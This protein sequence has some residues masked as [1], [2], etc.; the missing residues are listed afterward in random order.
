MRVAL[1]TKSETLID[2]T[3]FMERCVIVPIQPSN[4]RVKEWEFLNTQENR[5]LL[6]R[7]GTLLLWNTL[8]WTMDDY[9]NLYK[10]AKEHVK[11]FA[12]TR[13]DLRINERPLANMAV[14]VCGLKFLKSTLNKV[15]VRE[16][17][18]RL[19]SLC[20][21]I[22]NEEAIRRVGA[23]KAEIYK[24]LSD[25]AWITH[26]EPE[27]SA[28]ALRE[29]TEY[30]YYLDAKGSAYLDIDVRS[31][32]VKYQSW[33]KAR[34]QQSHYSNVEGFASALLQIPALESRSSP[35]SPL[36]RGAAGVIFR[37]RFEEIWA[38][39]VEHFKGKLLDGNGRIG[40]PG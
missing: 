38:E 39:D 22:L 37:F 40:Q 6:S 24:A 30:C 7:L 28:Y 20:N 31:V 35:N 29:G 21:S 14:V 23:P 16:L 34:H 4:Q 17:D 33:C 12:A 3:A 36:R 32:Y 15:G 9:A 5:I 2:E 26:N 27:D 13:P 25:V 1:C 8:R 19:D 10:E 11:A 18:Q